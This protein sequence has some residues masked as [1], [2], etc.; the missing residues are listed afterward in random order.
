VDFPALSNPTHRMD[1]DWEAVKRFPI[2]YSFD[3]CFVVFL[4]WSLVE[5]ELWVD[6]SNEQ[7]LEL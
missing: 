7:D 1:T 3:N 4:S 5:Y 2:I 6:D